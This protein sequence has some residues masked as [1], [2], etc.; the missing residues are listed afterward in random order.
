MKRGSQLVSFG[1]P[2]VA[3]GV[4][5]HART[6][7]VGITSTKKVDAMDVQQKDT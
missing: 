5:S 1:V 4:V 6:L 7:T 3:A 2:L